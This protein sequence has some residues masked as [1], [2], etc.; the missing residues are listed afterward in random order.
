MTPFKILKFLFFTPKYV[1]VPRRALFGIR[2][3]RRCFVYRLCPN[4]TQNAAPFQSLLQSQED[5]LG[6]KTRF[7]FGQ[8]LTILKP[9]LS[10]HTES[11]LQ[12]GRD[13]VK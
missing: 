5:F 7:F 3:R 12:R 2:P 11:S 4:Y 13:T 1:S 6:K 9:A 8:R 10:G